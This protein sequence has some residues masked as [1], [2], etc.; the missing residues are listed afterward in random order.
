MSLSYCSTA[1]PATG[2]K[3]IAG[4][5][6]PMNAET[7]EIFK[8]L[9]RQL[10]RVLQAKKK[11]L[12]DVDG[13][14]GPAAVSAVDLA[15]SS[16]MAMGI[17][18]DKMRSIDAIAANAP[19]VTL[20]VQ[21]LANTLS[22]PAAADPKPSSPPSLPGPNGTVLHPPAEQMAASLGGISLSHPLVFAAVGVGVLLLLRGGVK[23]RRRR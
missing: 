16:S 22:A 21:G 7:L 11:K 18:L 1:S 10:N 20:A 12:V 19:A 15:R 5:A 9:Q 8:G 14:I 23:R 6:I 2:C 3:P 13:R 17:L 4:I